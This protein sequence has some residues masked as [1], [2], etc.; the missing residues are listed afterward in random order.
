MAR[1]K[2]KPQIVPTIEPRTPWREIPPRDWEIVKEYERNG[3]SIRQIAFDYKLTS[4]RIH[5]ILTKYHVV[6]RPPGGVKKEEVE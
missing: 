5:Q 4:S 2:S 6:M 1:A 3:L